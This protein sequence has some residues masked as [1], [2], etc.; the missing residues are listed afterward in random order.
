MKI[1]ITCPASLPATQFGGILIFSVNLAKRL[2]K[3]DHNVTIYTTDLNFS[4][5]SIIFDK[6]LPRIEKIDKFT[7][8]RS[9]VLFHIFLFLCNPKI[10]SQIRN[11]KPDIIHAVGIR[12]FQ[13]FVSA[14]LSKFE[15]IPLVL[16]D[17]GGLTTHPDIVKGS[18]FKRVAY[19]FQKPILRF[20]MNQASAVIAA[21]EYEI[22]DFSTLV[23]REKIVL[24]PNGIDMDSLQKT[25]IDFKSKY[26]ISDR[27]IL[28]VGRFDKVK[29]VDILLQAFSKVC[30][31]SRFN[32]VKLVI[33]GAN[34]GFKNEMLDII[35]RLKIDKQVKIIENPP[36]EDVISAYHA[37]EFLVLPSRWELSPLTPLEGFA[38]K[39]TVI[40]T[41]TAGIP[42]VIQHE[43]SGILVPV[44]NIEELAKSIIM[45]LN[46]KEKTSFLANNG[47]ASV[48]E[49]FNIEKMTNDIVSI[50]EEILNIKG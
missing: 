14:L 11:D 22:S 1:A 44:D 19:K 8:K 17:Y 16:S 33:M 34:F 35:N 9:H 30:E 24:V 23:K 42:Y 10:Y 25:E 32:N 13:S 3:L 46:D 37:C 7:I 2:G 39:K 26:K 38:C 31:D 15:K 18:I 5:S 43:N 29:G 50:Y 45:L 48:K 6:N 47:Y 12:A 40:S 49:K 20:I 27:I 28:F 4:G 36:R 21:N 41:N